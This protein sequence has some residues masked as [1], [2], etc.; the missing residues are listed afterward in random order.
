MLA[1]MKE[2]VILRW[3][4]MKY[5][6]KLRTYWIV[7]I[8]VIHAYVYVL[9]CSTF[10]PWPYAPTPSWHISTLSYDLVTRCVCDCIGYHTDHEFCPNAT[11]L[12]FL[13]NVLIAIRMFRNTSGQKTVIELNIFVHLNKFIYVKS[14]ITG[15]ADI[16]CVCSCSCVC[17][18]EYVCS[19]MMCVCV[20]VCART[21]EMK[22]FSNNLITSFMMGIS[23]TSGRVNTSVLFIA[24]LQDIFFK[25]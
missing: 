19:I 13:K 16:V 21:C 22:C 4:V 14:K 3:R 24:S 11:L 2:Q 7:L 1:F 18:S 9:T 8:A 23:C 5:L 12:H 10:W 6:C 17:M 20:F 15:A 25:I